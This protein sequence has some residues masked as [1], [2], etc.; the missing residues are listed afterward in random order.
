MEGPI[1]CGNVAVGNWLYTGTWGK[2]EFVRREALPS[3]SRR[4]TLVPTGS[5][6]ARESAPHKGTAKSLA[7]LTAQADPASAYLI[8]P[9]INLRTCQLSAAC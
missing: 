4:S 8:W 1:Y 3:V 7:G 2:K 6:R 9:I 5:S